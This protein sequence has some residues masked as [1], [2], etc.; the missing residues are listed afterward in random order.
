MRFIAFAWR[1]YYPSGGM[2]DVVGFH[3]TLES[4]QLC[5]ENAVSKDGVDSFG[6]VFDAQ[7]GRTWNMRIYAPDDGRTPWCRAER[8]QNGIWTEA[9]PNELRA[10]TERSP[11]DF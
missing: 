7:T 4:A 10:L 3:D 1:V 8:S 5:V 11:R 6:Q 9:P 2:N